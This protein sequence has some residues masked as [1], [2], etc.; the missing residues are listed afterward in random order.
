MTTRLTCRIR[1]LVGPGDNSNDGAQTLQCVADFYLLPRHDRGPRPF[2][3]VDVALT[4]PY[5]SYAKPVR[6]VLHEER[7]GRITSAGL[8][9]RHARPVRLRQRLTVRGKLAIAMQGLSRPWP[10][11]QRP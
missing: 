3:L 6:V 2:A 10:S 11:P 8:P 5:L 7:G 9:I 1:S 4:S